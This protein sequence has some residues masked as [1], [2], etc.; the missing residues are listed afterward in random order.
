MSGHKLGHSVSDI[1][2][3]KDPTKSGQVDTFRE[4][5]QCIFDVW[6]NYESK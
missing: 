5:I 3:A 1:F 6:G 4:N 2:V